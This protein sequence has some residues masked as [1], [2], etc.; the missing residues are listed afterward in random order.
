MFLKELMFL[1]ILKTGNVLKSKYDMGLANM[2][3]VAFKDN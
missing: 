3:D 2:V 1:N